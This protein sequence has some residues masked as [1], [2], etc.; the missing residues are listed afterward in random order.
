MKK[1][2]TTTKIIVLACVLSLGVSSV[3]AE[4]TAAPAN[5][6]SNNAPTPLNVSSTTQ[7]KEGLL[8]TGGLFGKN[9]I[10]V[11]SGKA[12]KYGATLYSGTG[13]ETIVP[14]TGV[15]MMSA[16]PSLSNFFFGD[17]GNFSMTGSSNVT[18]GLGSLKSNT[19]GSYNVAIGS[20]PNAGPL[21][22]NTT[23]SNNV[24]VGAGALAA[25]T[26]GSFNSAFG[27]TALS[28]NST[29]SN[30][31]AL[32]SGSLSTNLTGSHNI[33]IG[34]N[35]IAGLNM[36]G[37]N[38]IG[39][40]QNAIK[41]NTSGTYNIGLGYQSLF[42]NNSGAS[43]IAVGTS[44]LTGNTTGG[45]NIAIG[46]EAL[47]SNTTGGYNI[48]IGNGSLFYNMYGQYNV[49]VGPGS[50]ASTNSSQNTG[51]GYGAGSANTSGNNNV[52]LGYNAL[53]SVTNGYGNTAVGSGANVNTGSTS[54]STAVGYGAI[55]T[56]NNSTVIGAGATTP[57]VYGIPLSNSVI[58]GNSAVNFVFTY[59]TITSAKNMVATAF[60]CTVNNYAGCF[61]IPSDF[62]LKKDIKEDNLG[63]DFIMKLKPVTFKY[64]KGAGNTLNGLIAQEVEQA[65]KELNI[66]FS[67]LVRPSPVNEYYSLDY[68][69]FVVP[70]IN[71][72]QDQQK[73]IDELKAKNAN[74]EA[75]LKALEEKLR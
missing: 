10:H 51:L 33:G 5:P 19:T 26:S 22:S 7:S 1:I 12:Y 63:L 35:A 21:I 68:S 62:R 14:G 54:N 57:T 39:I 34:I 50:F 72:V 13:T 3:F 53:S 61:R 32:G 24:A 56:G 37:S 6:P 49:T 67:G 25:N 36:S 65:L 66:N 11:A 55:A 52:A 48:A 40:G 23:G 69:N 27:T 58:L 70:L 41:K 16:L 38:N 15:N 44:A 75:R 29:G 74:F 60:D 46:T 47:K 4:W 18:L 28:G 2:L 31:V 30:N 8:L 45:S 59:G 64:K 17:T 43:N 9:D 42:N 73:E 20:L 71:A